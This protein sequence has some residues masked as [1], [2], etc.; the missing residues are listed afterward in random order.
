MT[1][2]RKERSGLDEETESWRAAP[3]GDLIEH[4]L[5]AY[6]RPLKE[7]LPRLESMAHQV[8]EAHA[9]SAKTTLSDVLST[10]Q[11]L[12]IELEQHMAK[13]EQILFPMIQRG[14]GAMAEG[15][16]AVMHE[17]H[18]HAQSALARLRALTDEYAVPADAGE[19]WRGLWQ[20][21]QALEQA[22]HR[23]IHLENEILF[24]RAL[25][26]AP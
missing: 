8:L 7:D 14:Q 5:Q 4:I 16:I 12:K 23:H 25:S 3:L 6:H 13:E 2:E 10:F 24:P 15:P 20:G 18:D 21:L 1:T 11:G 19:T 17:E 22:L 26:S 9:D